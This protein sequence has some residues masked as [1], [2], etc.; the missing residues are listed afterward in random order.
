M[1]TEKDI[2]KIADLSCLEVKDEDVP[3]LAK[4]LGEIIDYV[5]Q[6]GDLSLDGI[7]PTAHAVEVKNVFRKT[8]DDVVKNDAFKKTIKQAPEA[9]EKYFR[10]PKVL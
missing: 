2:K 7:K 9:D 4:Q 8:D 1:I 10:V 5:E 3:K 6:L